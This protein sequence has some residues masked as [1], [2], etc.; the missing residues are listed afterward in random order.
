MQPGD[1]LVSTA[2]DVA[3][4]AGK[5]CPYCRVTMTSPRIYKGNGAAYFEPGMRNRKD[6]ATKDH[7]IPRSRLW[8]LAHR[9]LVVC[10]RC[11]NDKGNE[12]LEEWLATLIARKDIR[13]LHVRNLLDD[14]AILALARLPEER[15]VQ[16]ESAAIEEGVLMTGNTESGE[17]ARACEE[18]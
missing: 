18:T 3:T 13:A 12:T 4:W 14:P 6:S 17:S 1:L 8:G 15:Q 10:A 11:N 9:I 16:V 7:V 5:P 2:V